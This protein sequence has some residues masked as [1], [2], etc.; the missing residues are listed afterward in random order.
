MKNSK[1]KRI[2]SKFIKIYKKKPTQAE[3]HYF[4]THQRTS[5]S[6]ETYTEIMLNRFLID[7]SYIPNEQN[8][9]NYIKEEYTK[10]YNACIDPSNYHHFTNRYKELVKLK[11]NEKIDLILN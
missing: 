7:N 11:R 2:V 10:I 1:E 5:L 3:V 4:L 6:I 8:F 9:L